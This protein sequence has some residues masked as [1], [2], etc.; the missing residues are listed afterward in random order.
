[1]KLKKVI[2]S[3]APGTGKSSI[4]KELKIRGY[5][6]FEEVWKKEYKNPSKKYNSDYINIFSKH[7]FSERL[8]HLETKIPKTKDQVIFYDRSIIDTISY[9]NNYKKNIE[10]TWLETAIKK[11][12]YE[13]IFFCPLWKEI[14]KQ[15]NERKESFEETMLIEKTLTSTYKEF[16]YKIKNVPKLDIS[17][18]VDYI[19]KNI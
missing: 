1:M 6:C 9:L 5:F 11:R 12:Y 4:I 18:R 10:S 3:G 15:T 19:L 16:L 14:Y 17:K 13:T 2:I 7:L 8:K